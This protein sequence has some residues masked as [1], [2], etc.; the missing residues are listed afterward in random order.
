MNAATRRVKNIEIE[1][2]KKFRDR[3]KMTLMEMVIKNLELLDLKESIIIDRN[4]W[5]KKGI[6]VLDH[7]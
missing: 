4:V 3:Q 5:R 7:S 1:R 2:D 6:H